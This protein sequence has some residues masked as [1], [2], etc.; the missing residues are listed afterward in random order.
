MRGYFLDKMQFV[1]SRP[2]CLKMLEKTTNGTNV[3]ETIRETIRMTE[4]ER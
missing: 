3:A 1:I 2:E 4:K